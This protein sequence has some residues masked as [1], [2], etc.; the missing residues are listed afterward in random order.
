MARTDLSVQTIAQAGIEPSYE[1]ANADGEAVPN[2]G[3]M[4]I[5]VKNG[6]GSQITVTIQTPV[7]YDGLALEDQTVTIDAG[8]EKM[9]GPFSTRFNQAGGTDKGKV[10]VDFSAVTSVTIAA[11]RL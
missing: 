1:A 11:F 6:G 8:D 10:Y 7:A 4:F 3:L 9:I 5:H 2:N